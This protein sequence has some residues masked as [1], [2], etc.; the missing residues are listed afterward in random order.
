LEKYEEASGQKLN[1]DKTSIFFSRNTS[2]EKREEISRL[3]GLSATQCYEKYLGLP[4]MVGRSRYQAFKGIQDRV[5]TRLND[6]KIKFLSQAGKEILIKAV[7]QAI[8]TYT[9]SVFLLPNSL[10][11]E[12]NSLMERFWWGHKDNNSKIHW[13]SW[14]KMGVSKDQGGLGFR[15]L[16]MF[17]KALLAKQMW[18]I[19]K[20]PDSLVAKIMKAKYFPHSSVM[21]ANLGNRPS[22][23]WRSLLAAKEMVH[24]GAIW[25]VGD[26]KD[27]RVWGDKWLPTPSSFSI[28][29]PR[30]NQTEDWKVCSLID[31][32]TKQ[33][34]VPLVAA[35][36][37]PDEA[38]TITNIPLSPFQP[39][40]RLI[41][42]C[43]KNGEFSV[44]SAYHL[45]MSMRAMEKAGSS[46]SNKTGDL[47]KTCWSLNV[48]YAVK[49]YVWRACHNLLP[50]KVNLFKRGVCEDK[51]CPI[52]LHEEETVAHVN[53]GCP[54]ANDVWG[55]SRMKLQKSNCDRSDF[56]QI[57]SEVSSKCNKE[58][59]ELFAV[60]AR[61]LWLRRN[62]VVHGG[63][64]M[65]PN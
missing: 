18:R 62:D 45:G 39:K 40:D 24:N 17:N 14:E 11:K 13:M 60:L 46:G 51:V 36:F 56:L 8:P 25:R 37:R 47:W 23:V 16:C 33:W 6:W 32:D 52:C 2:P 50:T 9:M 59:I 22:Q 34:N 20:N 1:K 65:H 48:P 44:K 64:L 41:W 49:M 58:E 54:A 19:W 12:L 43:T 42:R 30:L 57:F 3:S 31:Q 10:C 27:I 53:W 35:N 55:S 15:D 26:G 7:I 38:A 4:T 28:Q 63:I 61:R 21:E 5:W 29:S